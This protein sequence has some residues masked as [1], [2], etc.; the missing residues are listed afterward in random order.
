MIDKIIQ[1]IPGGTDGLVYG[2]GQSGD[3]YELTSECEWEY[4]ASSPR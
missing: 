2:L 3:L 4:V 1:I